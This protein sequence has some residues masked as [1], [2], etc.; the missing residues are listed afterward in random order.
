VVVEDLA[1]SGFIQKVTLDEGKGSTGDLLYPAQRFFLAVTEVV[2]GY[3]F[4]A[5]LQ[6]FDTGVGADI[7]GAAG[8]KDGGGHF[9]RSMNTRS[10]PG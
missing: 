3:D 7:S 1:Q 9:Q 8:Y 6:Q 5:G 2:D 10:S 4:V